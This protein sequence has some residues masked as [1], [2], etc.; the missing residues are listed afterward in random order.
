MEV[1][2]PL[3]QNQVIDHTG[4]YRIVQ[5]TVNGQTG[6]VI[7]EY[8]P[9]PEPEEE[10]LQNNN[11]TRAMIIDEDEKNEENNEENNNN[12]QMVLRGQNNVRG[13]PDSNG[14]AIEGTFEININST[15]SFNNSVSYMKDNGG[16]YVATNN[17]FDDI[18][19]K[20]WTFYSSSEFLNV[21][22]GNDV[23]IIRKNNEYNRYEIEMYYNISTNYGILSTGSNSWVYLKTNNN[24]STV[25]FYNNND[26]TLLRMIDLTS[27]NED[28]NNL[29]I[30]TNLINFNGISWM[31]FN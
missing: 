1:S 24:Y 25:T 27:N 20:Y 11:N 21:S 10:V 30:N 12:G 4:T 6:L 29:Y 26:E 7:E 28:P 13:L 14:E 5:R 31:T 2:I 3:I 23:L 18:Y 8:I 9:E 19:S 22:N 17:N 15:P 16:H